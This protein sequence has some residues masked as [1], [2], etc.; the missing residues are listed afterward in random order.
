[1]PPAFGCCGAC[2]FWAACSWPTGVLENGRLGAIGNGFGEEWIFMV[3]ATVIGGVGMDGGKGTIL[4]AL[5]GVL[6]RG[7]VIGLVIGVVQSILT[8]IGV[9]G[10]WQLVIYGT[11]HPHRADDQLYCR[12][13]AQD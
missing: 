4:G 5:T 2:S 8:L 6:V 12:G 3:F 9:F 7:L 1:M 13:K 11:H 10:F